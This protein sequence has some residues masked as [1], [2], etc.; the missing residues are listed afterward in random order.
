VA[1]IAVIAVVVASSSDDDGPT[2]R[3]SH[4]DEGGFPL[5]GGAKADDPMIEE[6]AEAWL[7]DDAREGD[8]GVLDHDGEAMRVLWAGRLGDSETVV[9]AAD[10]HAALLRRKLDPKGA[11]SVRG[12]DEIRNAQDPRIISFRA[13][14]LVDD[15][16]EPAFMPARVQ[17]NDVAPH[18]GLW[19][20]GGRYAA[21]ELLPAGALAV[22][23]GLRRYV[24]ERSPPAT[25]VT[26]EQL[27]TW[28]VDDAL[29]D[30][31]MPGTTTFAPPA[32][33]RFVAA[34]TPRTS[35]DGERRQWDRGG[36]PPE[37]RLVQDRSLPVLGSTMVLTAE[38]SAARDQMLAAT[39]G[40]WTAGKDEAEPVNL[41]PPTSDDEAY[42]GDGPPLAAA[43]VDRATDE[44]PWRDLSVFVAGGPEIDTIEVLSGRE[45]VTR[46]G[47]VAVIPLPEATDGASDTRIRGDLAV[48]GRTAGGRVVVPST[49][50]KG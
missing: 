28:I 42:G 45:T 23:N 18:D 7:A 6:A 24:G 39:G 20:A 4:S 48:I 43:L 12:I 11:F 14:V 15:Q 29:L 30:K 17:E 8:D 36:E 5:R 19:T 1:V 40:S 47:P 44:R 25:V 2:L 9:L 34:V 35:T 31:L 33:Q 16:A 3:I 37:L 10:R 26:G 22:R 13:A 32:Y 21:S 46:P 41:S 50:T 27:S 49:I 38:G